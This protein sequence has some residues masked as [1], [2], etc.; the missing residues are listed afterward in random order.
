MLPLSARR[1]PALLLALVLS[2]F[3]VSCS[4]EDEPAVAKAE[5]GDC[6]VAPSSADG[7]WEVVDCGR[8]ARD[9]QVLDVLDEAEADS[10]SDSICTDQADFDLSLSPVTGEP[11]TLC[12]RQ[13]PEVGECVTKGEYVDCEAGTG[14]DVLAV[15]S[16]TKTN[17]CPRKATDARVYPDAKLTVCLRPADASA[18]KTG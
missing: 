11:P 18:S 4:G 14:N 10:S 3:V 17:K 1:L 5:Q 6:V 16:G 8:E 9:Y 13:T 15:E 12:L 2:V 7:E